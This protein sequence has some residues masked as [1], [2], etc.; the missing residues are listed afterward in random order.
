[1][2]VVRGRIDEGVGC[3]NSRVKGGGSVSPRARAHVTVR[4]ACS[5]RKRGG[6]VRA[7][8]MT[9]K[10]FGCAFVQRLRYSIRSAR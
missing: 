8:S 3:L 4:G 9:K 10:G 1:M 5:L 6:F 7:H 2:V